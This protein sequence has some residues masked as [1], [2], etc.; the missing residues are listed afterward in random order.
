MQKF[1][2]TIRELYEGNIATLSDTLKVVIEL[3]MTNHAEERMNRHDKPITEQ[4]IINTANKAIDDIA[5]MILH[6]D[7]KLG[8]KY[9]I[10]DPKADNLNLVGQIRRNP[11][12][13]LAF[14]IITVMRVEVFNASPDCIKIV[15]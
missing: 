6:G 12:H 10:F 1:V 15:V 2:P 11:G 13:E 3:E 4:E 14:V 5:N 8:S 9:H 7:A